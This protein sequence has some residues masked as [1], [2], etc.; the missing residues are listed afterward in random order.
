MAHPQRSFLRRQY[1]RLPRDWPH[2]DGHWFRLF[3]N[4]R[5]WVGLAAGSG[6]APWRQRRRVGNARDRVGYPGQMSCNPAIG[7]IGKGHL[8]RRSTRSAGSWAARRERDY[9]EHPGLQ[10]FDSLLYIRFA[11]SR[12]GLQNYLS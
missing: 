11:R 2:E 7:G 5:R 6:G 1:S 8:V 10:R 4:V 9:L 12:N 3:Q